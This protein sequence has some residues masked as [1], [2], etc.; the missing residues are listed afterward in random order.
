MERRVGSLLLTESR[1][2]KN[3][4]RTIKGEMNFECPK[5][6]VGRYRRRLRGGK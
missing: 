3:I 4:R 5:S 6:E 1:H 2:G